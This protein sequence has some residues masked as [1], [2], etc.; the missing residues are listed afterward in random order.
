[1]V[2]NVKKQNFNVVLKSTK[3]WPLLK[4]H[5]YIGGLE[6]DLYCL[7]DYELIKHGTIRSLVPF[8]IQAVVLCSFLPI[9][10]L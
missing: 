5:K 7:L 8:K 2:L 6:M 9:I 10:S 4:N 3:K 1:M